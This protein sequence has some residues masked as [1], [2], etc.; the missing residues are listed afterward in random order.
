MSKKIKYTA[1]A[2][3]ILITA[4]ASAQTS[5]DEK[6]D[7]NKVITLE[8]EFDPVKKEV[9]KKTVLPQE[10]KKSTKE[11]VAPQFSDWTVP[12]LVPVDIP[13]MLPYGYRTLHNFSNQ[14]GY[15]TVGMGT[16]LNTLV[17]AGYRITDKDNEKLGVWLQHNSTWLGKNTSKLIE[18]P[19][20]RQKQR[21]NDNLLGVGWSKELTK[22][23]LGVDGRLHF[24]SFNYYGGFSDYLKNNKTAF[25]EAR[26]DGKWESDYK[27]N[28]ELI[29]YEA[30]ATIDY[31]G[32]DKSH[33]EGIS[34]AKE[35]WLGAS[36]EGEYNL[37]KI[38]NVGLLFG[39]DVMNLRRHNIVN[40]IANDKTYGMLTLNPYYKYSNDIFTAKAGAV[41]NFSFND[42]TAV[43]FAPDVDLNFKIIKGLNLFAQ[44][45]G[46]KEI[47]HLGGM[48]DDYRY[49]DP[50]AGYSNTYIPFDGRVGV[51][52]GPFV[53]FSGKLYFG[54]GFETGCLD[55]VIPAAN[56]GIYK[57]VLDEQNPIP[58]GPGSPYKDFNQYAATIYM[59]TKFKGAYVGA[60]LAYKYRSLAEAKVQFMY[61]PQTDD[62]YVEGMRYSGYALGNDG[63]STL[64]NLDVKVWPI[65]P[66]MVT[67]GLSCRLNRCV[68]TRE[69][70]VVPE[71][72]EDGTVLEPGKYDID[73]LDLNDVVDLHVGARYS[74]SHI[75]S[76]WAQASNL[77]CK[78]WDIMPGHGAQKIGLMGGISLNF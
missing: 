41:I 59:M 37:E 16:C 22:G 63:P 61:A 48:H 39:A 5:G 35:F 3:A 69:W 18:Q 15:L 74:F 11:A 44:A 10:I 55:A 60:E 29:E 76:V 19:S 56:S 28:D 13:T 1:L 32:Y 62:E 4:S 49:N 33:L 50:L 42:G 26:V 2:A 24:D 43:R 12:A 54:Y 57:E 46:G 27:F 65:K 30:N 75:F 52:V 17:N 77:L 38:G 7:L 53:G 40:N 66:L 71:I 23:T 36:I 20:Q 25:V 68:M 70:V 58:D 45:T 6:K 78:Q 64:F 9:V 51:N 8:R 21:F 14:R 31:A 73:W 72:D 34:G 47:N 67:A